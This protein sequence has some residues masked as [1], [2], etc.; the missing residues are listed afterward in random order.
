MS[1]GKISGNLTLVIREKLYDSFLRKN[2]GWFD[3][4]ENSPG[5]LTGI[6]SSEV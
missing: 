6:L 5:V 2:I 3:D 1:F 4:R